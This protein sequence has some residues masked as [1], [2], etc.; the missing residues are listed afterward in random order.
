MSPPSPLVV[1]SGRVAYEAARF[2][3]LLPTYLHILASALFLVYTA[4]HASLSIP[5]SAA[6]PPRKRPDAHDDDSVDEEQ[7]VVAESK[8]ALK[9]KDA[10]LF[11]LLAGLTLSSLYF[12]IKWLEDPSTLNKILSYYYLQVGVVFG[13]KFFKDAFVVVRSFFLPNQYEESGRLWRINRSKHRYDLVDANSDSEQ[14]YR[15]SHLPGR[16]HR[17]PISTKVADRAWKF[18]SLLYAKCSLNFHIHKLSSIKVPVD[19]LD[20]LAIST[21]LAVVGFFTFL[22]KPWYISNLIGFTFCYSSMQ[23]MSPTT[24]WTGTLLQSALF[25]YDIY[26]VFFTPMMMAVA[27]KVDVPI[28][29]LFPRPAQSERGIGGLAILG[30]GDIMIPGMMIA[31]ALRFDLYLHY[32]RQSKTVEGKLEKA[33]YLP[34]SGAWGERFWVGRSVAGPDLRA[35][36]FPKTYFRAGLVGYSVSLI[37]TL[38]VMQISQHGQ[39]ALLYLVPGVLSALWGTAA[40]KGELGQM[41]NYTEDEEAA[42]PNRPPNQKKETSRQSVE[43]ENK[44]VNLLGSSKNIAPSLKSTAAGAE[45][46]ELTTTSIPS[47]DTDKPPE[48]EGESETSSEPDSNPDSDTGFATPSSS[49]SEKTEQQTSKLG[50]ESKD[51]EQ[52]CR[53]LIWFSIDFPPSPPAFAVEEE[54]LTKSEAGAQALATPSSDGAET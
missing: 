34:V 41:W 2:R 35:K 6:P 19:I 24:F 9:P 22:Y 1:W 26:F 33:T 11:P 10:I 23:Y 52:E 17:L 12:I 38:L 32:L 50:K 51:K 45:N 21:S 5:S 8:E 37:V 36:A 40:M 16:L 42:K 39:P 4:A 43:E 30:L 53:H 54:A 14:A 3:R 15:K 18:R 48:L 44:A 20:A 31:H 29:L 13:T 47:G 46:E 27:T 7:E 49:H 28:K 25:F